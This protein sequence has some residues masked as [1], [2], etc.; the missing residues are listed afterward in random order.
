ML[1]ALTIEASGGH[2]LAYNP[3]GQSLVFLDRQTKQV[4][5]WNLASRKVTRKLSIEVS[6][7]NDDWAASVVDRLLASGNLDGRKIGDAESGKL[8]PAITKVRDAPIAASPNGRVVAGR[9]PVSGSS[10]VIWE[11]ATGRQLQ[12]LRET[13][14][15]VVALAFSPDGRS[16]AAANG[17]SSPCGT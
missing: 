7:S 12:T 9:D 15:F 10:A 16:L 6:G 2:F 13:T 4:S 8:V 5:F 14:G 3:D 17:K 11:L 1:E